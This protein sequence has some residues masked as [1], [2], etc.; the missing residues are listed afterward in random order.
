MIRIDIATLF[1]DMCEA[2]LSQSIVGRGRAAG[3]IDIRCHNIRDYAGTA[4]I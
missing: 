1:P 2:V 4:D 3:Y